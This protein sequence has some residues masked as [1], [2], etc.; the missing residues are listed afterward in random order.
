MLRLILVVLLCCSQLLAVKFVKDILPA[1]G[2]V[3]TI[4]VN[5]GTIWK[6]IKHPKM[7]VKSVVK[8]VKGK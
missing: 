4:T 2:A 1:A 6:S 7:T 5:S 8:K 3:T